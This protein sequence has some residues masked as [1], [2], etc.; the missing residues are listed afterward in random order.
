MTAFAVILLAGIG[1]YAAR[2]VFILGVGDTELSPQVERSLR[3]VGPAVLAALAASLLTS[4]DGVAAFVSDIPTLGGSL[5][6]GA[7]A[8]R[9]RRFDLSFVAAAAVFF[10]L[11]AIPAFQ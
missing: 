2:S 7:T 1:T 3:F 4:P 11:D 5:V 9:F 6:A 8:W 10:I